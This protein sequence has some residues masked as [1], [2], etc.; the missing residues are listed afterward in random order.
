[1][2]P[3]LISHTLQNE[4][5]RALGMSFQHGDL[6]QPPT[7]DHTLHQ[8]PSSLQH[9]W[10]W[11]CLSYTNTSTLFLGRGIMQ[12]LATMVTRHNGNKNNQGGSYNFQFSEKWFLE[13][14]KDS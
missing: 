2:V 14:F 10:T 13:A 7:A 12:R 3:V 4:K 8:A 5:E 6:E 1:V 11:G 9:F